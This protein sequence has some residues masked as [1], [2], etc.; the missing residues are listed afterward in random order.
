MYHLESVDRTVLYQKLR[1]TMSQRI[2]PGEDLDHE[3]LEFYQVTKRVR[4]SLVERR[5]DSYGEVV[6][7]RSDSR[8]MGSRASVST[9]RK[10]VSDGGL[11]AR[12]RGDRRH[13]TCRA[14]PQMSTISGSE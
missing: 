4:Y 12:D 7:E 14:N 8:W 6:V 3:F 13:A 5:L 9:T 11:A 10:H 1:Q 2:E